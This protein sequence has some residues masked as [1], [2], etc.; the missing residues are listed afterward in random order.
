MLLLNWRHC[1]H[2]RKL[3]APWLH[4]GSKTKQERQACKESHAG[5]QPNKPNN[6]LEHSIDK[7]GLLYAPRLQESKL[8]AVSLLLRSLWG[9]MQSHTNQV[10]R[11]TCTY[12]RSSFKRLPGYSLTVS[13]ERLAQLQKPTEQDTVLQTL[14][15]TTLDGLNKKASHLFQ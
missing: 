10:C 11:C 6:I 15:T 13:S 7:I 12:S 9:R 2:G 4:P 14:Q 8:Q 1:T 5:N 3:V